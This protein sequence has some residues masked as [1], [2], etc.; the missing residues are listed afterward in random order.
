MKSLIK[1]LKE[2]YLVFVI[3]LLVVLMYGVISILVLKSSTGFPSDLIIFNNHVYSDD[4]DGVVNLIN[5]DVY[6]DIKEE[7]GDDNVTRS[8]IVNNDGRFSY[9]AVDNTFLETGVLTYNKGLEEDVV[10]SVELVAGAVWG[11]SSDD[12]SIIIDEK[13]ADYYNINESDIGFTITIGGIP[14]R[15]SGIVSNTD[16]IASD[17]GVILPSQFNTGAYDDIGNIYMPYYY[18]GL[19]FETEV[20]HYQDPSALIVKTD[21]YFSLKDD[22]SKL[23]EI[24]DGVHITDEVIELDTYSFDKVIESEVLE[25]EILIVMFVY[26]SASVLIF[27]TLKKTF[28]E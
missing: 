27:Y 19:D 24:V 7:F 13:V 26:Y 3:F 20:Y 9:F 12:K 5:Y 18:S 21:G 25:V 23:Q 2:K 8:T 1:F 28:F 10:Q 14:F 22:T 15:V 11:E 16:L 17:G 4:Q 6:S